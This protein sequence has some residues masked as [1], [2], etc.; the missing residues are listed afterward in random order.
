MLKK[1]R[2]RFILRV[3]VSR[4]PWEKSLKF[5]EIIMNQSKQHSILSLAFIITTP[6]RLFVEDALL[7]RL[8]LSICDKI[9]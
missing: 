4:K 2:K 8:Q 6:D 7:G 3:N 9:R 5:W 1:E